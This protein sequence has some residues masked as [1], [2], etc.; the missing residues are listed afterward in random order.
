MRKL[1]SFFKNSGYSSLIGV[2]FKKGLSLKFN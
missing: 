2:Y 1:G